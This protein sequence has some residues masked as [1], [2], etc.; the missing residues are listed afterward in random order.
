MADKQPQLN[1]FDQ[2]PL[3]KFPSIV[4]NEKITLLIPKFKKEWMQKWLIPPGKSKHI[5]IRLDETGSRVWNLLDDQRNVHEICQLFIE[6]QQISKDEAENWELRII[7]FLN[8]LV[9]NGFIEFK[10]LKTNRKCVN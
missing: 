8:E 2:I 4:E 3:R 9:K 7:Q 5:S 10:V 1:Y 6:M